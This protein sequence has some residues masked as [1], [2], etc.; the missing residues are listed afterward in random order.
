MP[1][2]FEIS[3]SPLVLAGCLATESSVRDAERNLAEAVEESHRSISDQHVKQEVGDIGGIKERMAAAET[4]LHETVVRAEEQYQRAEQT[5][6]ALTDLGRIALVAGDLATG[7]RVGQIFDAV[8]TRVED[9]RKSVDT[10]DSMVADTRTQVSDVKTE[11]ARHAT[12]IDKVQDS[13]ADLERTLAR[14]DEST[15]DKIAAASKDIGAL[16]QAKDDRERFNAEVK[17]Y[18]ENA[19]LSR[20][21]IRKFRE[22]TSG[23]STEEIIALIAAAG[24][25]VGG[26]AGASR[27]GKSRSKAEIDRI[28]KEKNELRDKVTALETRVVRVEPR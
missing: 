27:F 1:H 7:G 25:G 14:L 28:E 5:E 17:T 16:V 24:V 2:V 18:L 15:R 6:R 23:L 26:G 9:A 19:G 21:E 20:E 10:M 8:N 4:K 13:V 3:L 11:L 12:S 22:A